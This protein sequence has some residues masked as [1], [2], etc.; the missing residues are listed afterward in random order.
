MLK[1]INKD[2]K[3]YFKNSVLFKIKFKQLKYHRFYNG[4]VSYYMYSD[5][6]KLS[7][8]CSCL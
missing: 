2:Q 6:V 4:Q 1:F 3:I 7:Q 5:Q 8:P